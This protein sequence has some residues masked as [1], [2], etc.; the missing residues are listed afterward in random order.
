MDLRVERA[1]TADRAGMVTVLEACG[2][3]SFGILAP[4]TLYWV[5]RTVSGFVG[6]CGIEVG[7][8]CALLRSVGVMEGW[9]GKGIAERLIGCALL[10]ATRLDLRDMYLFSKDMGGYFQRLGWREVA[11]AEAAA[12]LPQAPQVRRYEQIGWYP[13]ERAFVRSA[14]V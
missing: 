14:T 8:R 1:T 13:D 6:T 3:S 9:R 4:G 5:C 2:L 11:V 12:R 7:D 10:E